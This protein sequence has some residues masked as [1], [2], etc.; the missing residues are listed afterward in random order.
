MCSQGDVLDLS[1]T[2][3]EKTQSWKRIKEETTEGEIEKTI[4]LILK[5]MHLE[6]YDVRRGGYGGTD[7]TTGPEFAQEERGSAEEV[8]GLSGGF[9]L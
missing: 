7:G 3:I 1:E 4:P 2:L 8:W 9:W 6:T 5:E